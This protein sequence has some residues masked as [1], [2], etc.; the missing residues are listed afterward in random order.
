MAIIG[1]EHPLAVTAVSAIHAGELAVLQSLLQGNLDLASSR[2]GDDVDRLSDGGTT[3][4]FLHVATD[5]PGHYPRVGETIGALIA[6]GAD[7][8]GRF[9]GPHTETP[10]HWA[11]SSDDIEA[12]DALLDHGADID[13]V[14]AV[15]GG[16]TPLADA[17]A[18]GQWV[19]ADRLISRGARV[20]IDDAATVGL[21]ERVR[22]FLQVDRPSVDAISRAFWGACHGGRLPAAEVLLAHGADINVLPPWEP[23]TPLDA[24]VRRGAADLVAWLRARGATTAGT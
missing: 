13:A 21:T 17:R 8:N 24:A 23:L 15:I 6:A 4:T 9:S 19:A 22:E 12:L 2:L 18:F 1:T 14:G 16:G 11:A 10:L 7:V 20:T 5:W 3:R